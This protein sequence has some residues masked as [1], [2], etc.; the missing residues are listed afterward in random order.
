MNWTKPNQN[1]VSEYKWTYIGI[2]PDD[3]LLVVLEKNKN[4]I[5]DLMHQLSDERLKYVYAEGKWTIKELLLHIIDSERV[6]AYRILC[7][8]RGEQKELPGYDENVYNEN[9]FANDRSK[10]SLIEEYISV[11][12]S[13]VSLLKFMNETCIQNKGT[14]NG[15]ISSVNELAYM[16]AGH[17]LH[18]LGVIKSKYL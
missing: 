2:V 6:F 1:S 7:F 3:D 9:S 13:T 14:A 10:E 4:T 17:E 12:N 11:R 18:H 5:V 8:L 15:S 16:I